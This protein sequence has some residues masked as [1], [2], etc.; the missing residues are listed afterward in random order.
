MSLEDI[1]RKRNED[2]ATRDKALD[3]TKKEIKDRNAKKIKDKKTA[4][5]PSKG[6]AQKAAPVAKQ[7]VPKQKPMKGG[8]R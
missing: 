6:P 7:N 8:K 3:A 4:T 1:K 2:A 5:K